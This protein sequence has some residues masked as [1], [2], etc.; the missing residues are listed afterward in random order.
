M[1]VQEHRAGSV[2][3]ALGYDG[4][5]EH[6]TATAEAFEFDGKK[7]L[8]QTWPVHAQKSSSTMSQRQLICLV[9]VLLK[10]ASTLCQATTSMGEDKLKKQLSAGHIGEDWMDELQPIIG[11]TSRYDR[12]GEWENVEHR[13]LIPA[14]P[15]K[16]TLGGLN[17]EGPLT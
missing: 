9:Q 2:Q 13:K 6:T 5:Q 3:S 11:L 4:D 1:L 7:Q 17:T 15:A 8:K 12:F 14:E 16:S 10:T